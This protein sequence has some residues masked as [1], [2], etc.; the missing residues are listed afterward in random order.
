M[1]SHKRRRH[2]AARHW[3]AVMAAGAAAGAMCASAAHAQT[4]SPDAVTQEGLRRQEERT[5]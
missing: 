2:G 1:G 3:L 5:R 4:A